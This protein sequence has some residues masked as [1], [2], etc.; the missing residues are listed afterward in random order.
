[1]QCYIPSKYNRKELKAKFLLH[2]QVDINHLY[3]LACKVW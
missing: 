3:E 1:M 2:L